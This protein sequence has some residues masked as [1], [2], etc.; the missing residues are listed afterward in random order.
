MGGMSYPMDTNNQNYQKTLS[1]VK[2]SI[3]KSI[4]TIDKIIYLLENEC[5]KGGCCK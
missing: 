4:Q 2:E 3:N 5:C 1:E